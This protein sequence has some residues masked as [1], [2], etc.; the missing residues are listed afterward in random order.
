MRERDPKSFSRRRE[1][2]ESHR[3]LRPYARGHARLYLMSGHFG[4]PRSPPFLSS[5]FQKSSSEEH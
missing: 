4:M 1:I 3:A 5:G 2:R